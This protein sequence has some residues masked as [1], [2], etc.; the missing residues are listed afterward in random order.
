VHDLDVAPR[1]NAVAVALPGLLIVVLRS[2]MLLPLS[3]TPGAL[4]LVGDEASTITLAAST[5]CLGRGPA[6]AP[7]DDRGVRAAAPVDRQ[8]DVLRSPLR[9]MVSPGHAAGA[10]CSPKSR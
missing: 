2:V 7:D 9:Q 4:G 6:V 5:G 10:C 1:T 8:S 3:A